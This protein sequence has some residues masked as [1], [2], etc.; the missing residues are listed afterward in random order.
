MA[1]KLTNQKRFGV[2][3]E[4]NPGYYQNFTWYPFLWEAG[5]DFQTKDGKSAF[6]TPGTVAALKFWQDAINTGVAPRKP[7]GGGA[8]DSVPNLGSGY[9]AMQN[10]GIW[11]IAQL[12]EGAPDFKY[13]VFRLP[14][15]PGG[16]YLTIGGGWAFVANAKGMESEGCW[17]VRRLVAGFAEGRL[18]RPD[19]RL[20]HQ[21]EER[22]AADQIRARGRQGCV[23]ER[24]PQDLHRRNLPRS[25]RGAA[26]ASARLQGDLGR[27]PGL[28]VERPRSRPSSQSRVRSDRR[29][30]LRLQRR[31]DPLMQDRTVEAPQGAHLAAPSFDRGPRLSNLARE[32]IAGYLFVAPD[33]IGLMI[34]VGGPM[35]LSL[36]L[37]FFSVS[38]FGEYTFVGLDNYRRMLG[39]PLFWRSL[40]VT[41]LYVVALVPLLYVVG[42]GLALLVQADTRFN[43]AIRTLL[44]MP[45]T[46]SLVVVALVWQVLVIDKIG[47]FN[48]LGA[49]IGIGSISWLGD[50][51][52]ALGTVIAISVWFLMGFYM[53]IFLGGLQDIPKEY[54]EA[55]RIDGAGPVQSFFEITLPL[56]RPTSFFV[57][58][59]STVTAVCGS[60]TFDLVYIMTKGGPAN[61]TSLAIFYIYQQA[62]QFNEYGYAAAMASVLVV[63]LMAITVLMFLLTQG[64]RFTYE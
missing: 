64:G 23:R 1:K 44:F 47:L 34:F 4:T 24:V 50:P 38:G 33:A 30:P 62:F 58:L 60:Q 14:T 39:D 7:L 5:G 25:A 19:R 17:R 51:R 55:A 27:H 42:L 26:H 31:A 40:Q 41:I 63:V 53:L 3:F 13:G 52:F 10:T 43:G 29:V 6:N 20:V 49:T 18:D 9:C 28:P 61:S 22:H 8:W 54:Y 12:R 21:G 16:K 11:A 35:I 45:Q 57:L 48:Q 59:V 32:R 37:G 15:P 46:V 56:L 2:L 36:S